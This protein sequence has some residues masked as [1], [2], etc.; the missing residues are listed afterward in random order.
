MKGLCTQFGYALYRMRSLLY[1]WVPSW[2][3]VGLAGCSNGDAASPFVEDGGS[4][5]DGGRD[6]ATDAL[7]D[8]PILGGPCLENDQCN[9]GVDC[10]FDACNL[11]IHRCQFTPDDSRCQ[12]GV[13]CDGIERCD[14]LL[15][16][17]QG[18][19]E[20][21]NDQATCTIDSCVE[22]TKTCEHKVRDADGDGNPDVHCRAGGDCDD[23]DPTVYTGHPEVCGN[24]KDDN[25]DGRID[26]AT[27]QKASHDTCLDPLTIAASGIY[28]LD[29]TAASFDYAGTCAPMAPAGRRDVVAALELTEAHDVDV[30]VEARAGTLAVGLAAECAKLGTELACADGLE[31]PSGNRL[32]RIRVRALPAGHYPLYV[33]TDRDETV[34]VHVSET[35]PTT[36]PSNET[37]GTATPLPLGA[38]LMVSLT[39]TKKDLESS[40]GFVTGDLVY[41]FTLADTRDVK[42]FAASTDGDGVP[43]VSLRKPDCAGIEDELVCGRGSPA[44]AF[45]RALPPGVYY[46]AISASAPTD[47]QVEVDVSAPTTAPADEKCEGAP[48]LTPN[49]TIDVGLTGHTD[50]IDLGCAHVGSVDAAYD[51]ELGMTS[52]VLLVERISDGDT[53]ALAL[54]TPTCADS[55]SMKACVTGRSSPLRTSVRGLAAGSY[56]VV[57]ESD[58]GNPVQVTAFVRTAVAPTLVA[59]ADTCA[60][61]VLIGEAGGFF[62]GNTANAAADYSSGCDVAGSGGA[63]GPD[64]MLK[65]VLTTKKRVIFDMQG[66]GYATLLDVRKGPS[67][68]GLEV[69]QGCSV[70][71]TAS[72]SFLDLTLEPGTYWVQVDGYGGEAGPWFLDVRAVNL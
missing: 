34:L 8:G 42:A 33:W 25:C 47:L 37:C 18:A 26:E 54:A 71:Y 9:D 3:A 13:Y 60:S 21:C 10:T 65:L 67:C 23:D 1:V 44:T 12:N 51:L 14:P 61:A 41:T 59:F 22:S 31:G 15:G 49:H 62:Q 40:C 68:P 63:G 52:D 66:S 5:P 19:P 11:A 36:P 4:S 20:A 7:T 24:H 2:L 56:R 48:L 35:S 16:C 72:R 17:R 6:A 27:C 50:D 46:L 29:T 43:V 28:Q 45:A 55:S 70:G 69:V 38:P 57:V 32:A 53:G 30:L 39:G 64:Q 58:R